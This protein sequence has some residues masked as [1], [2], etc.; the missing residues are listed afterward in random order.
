VISC[1]VCSWSDIRTGGAHQARTVP[2][3]RADGPWS[4]GFVAYETER[5]LLRVLEDFVVAGWACDEMVL[6]I[7]TPEQRSALCE[8]LGELG[9]GGR[10]RDGRLVELDAAATLDR[11]MVDG[12][13]DP[14]LFD[15][16]VGAVVRHH[17][18]N[19]PVRGFGEMVDLLWAE[20]NLVGALELEGLWQSLQDRCAL[21]LLCAYAAEHVDPAGRDTLASVH[22]YLAS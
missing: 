15:R 14:E 13:P 21:S 3:Q 18:A 9:L 12:L 8:R 16:T 1:T 6:L 10:L 2:T 7:A 20:G 5:D 22:D 11:F 4:H 19:A 17:T